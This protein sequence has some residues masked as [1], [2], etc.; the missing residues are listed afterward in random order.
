MLHYVGG[1]GGGVINI[2]EKNI[3]YLNKRNI[4]V[5]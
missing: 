4:F 1:G 2:N 5:G 3:F